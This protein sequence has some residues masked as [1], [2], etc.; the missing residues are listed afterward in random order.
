MRAGAGP[1]A[2]QRRWDFRYGVR[3][4]RSQRNP[5]AICVAMAGYSARISRALVC[6][7]EGGAG[8]S[9]GGAIVW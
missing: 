5:R 6:A 1:M 7:G 9:C 8:L 4:L 3:L 2:A